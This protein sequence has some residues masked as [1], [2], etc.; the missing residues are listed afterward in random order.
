MVDEVDEEQEQVTKRPKNSSL[1]RYVCC[2]P[3]YQVRLDRLPLHL[4]CLDL[5]QPAELPW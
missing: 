2:L 3:V 1:H 4:Y 5:T